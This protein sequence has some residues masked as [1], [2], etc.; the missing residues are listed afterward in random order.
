MPKYR[1][2]SFLACMF[3]KDTAWWWTQHCIDFVFWI[4]LLQR[5]SRGQH[6]ACIGATGRA[7]GPHLHFEGK[8]L[9]FCRC[10]WTFTASWDFT[11]VVPYLLIMCVHPPLCALAVRRNGEALDPFKWCNLWLPP[12]ETST[13][14][15]TY[16]YSVFL[17]WFLIC[18]MFYYCFLSEKDRFGVQRS[19]Y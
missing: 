12:P 6:V 16:H 4:V 1:I 11:C 13:E 7:T 5:V 19:H 15:G 17:V 8:F 3:W 2:M 14:P 10:V 9:F 18:V